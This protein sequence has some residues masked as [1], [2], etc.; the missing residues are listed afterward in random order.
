MLYC[1]NPSCPNPFNN[2]GY[3]FCQSCGAA[4]LLP[5]FRNRY[6]VIRQL[7]YGGF[8]RTYEAKDVDRMDDP[9]V[10]KQ[11]MPQV[12]GTAA[13]QKATELFKQEAQRLYELGEH[14]QIPG[15]I[16]YFEQDRRLYL[17]QEYIDGQNLLQEL[18]QKGHFNPDQ[19]YQ[20]LS[21]LLE[22]LQII[23]NRNI[24][25]RDIKPE[26]IMRRS[27]DNQL[28]LIDFGVSKQVTGTTTVGQGTTVGT[29]GYVPMEQL[30]GQ[31]YPASDLYSLGV[32]CLRLLT[33]CLPHEGG[34]DDLYDA[35]EGRWVWR[36]RLP[37]N[38]SVP[39]QL[40]EV[41]DGL[42]RDFVRD[43]YQSAQEVL[44]IIKQPYPYQYQPI[45]T[46]NYQRIVPPQP[47]NIPKR[48]TPPPPTPK[49]TPKLNPYQKLQDLMKAGKWR[50]ADAET[51]R[52]M[53]EIVG[54]QAGCFSTAQ[55]ATFPCRE[56][57]E[58]NQ[59]WE[60]ASGGRFGFG[61]QR[62][63]WEQVNQNTTEFAQRVGWCDRQP[64]D[65]IYVKDYDQLSFS[66]KAP[67]GH[68]PAL[69]VMAGREWDRTLWL[70]EHLFL[71]VEACGL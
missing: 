58:I 30:R 66:L 15:L 48:T 43:R 17:V 19:I 65:Q 69:S 40:A 35:M 10:I 37:T 33:G 59:V 4:I 34:G 21:E 46:Q 56:L 16:A 53:L 24:I 2:E 26:N 6:R 50:E 38:T 41:L 57:R 49:V 42:T 32:T 27:R 67:Q 52:L 61:V 28:I 45:P 62:R 55:I 60:Q 8:S 31:V 1:C 36:E 12:Q 7:G 9:C 25:H 3:R 51:S 70:L 71:S 29:P 22:I 5:L 44:Q 14:P 47:K 18:Q 39:P 54:S 63:I 64:S 68:L 13:R 11:F 20:I 23:H